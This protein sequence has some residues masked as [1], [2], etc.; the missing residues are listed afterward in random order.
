MTPYDRIYNILVEQYASARQHGDTEYRR[1]TITLKNDPR[2]QN[3]SIAASD[4]ERRRR[5]RLEKH[6]KLSDAPAK[7]IPGSAQSLKVRLARKAPLRQATRG[8]YR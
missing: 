4:A 1:N 5:A 3:P 6:A 8:G 2:R 7:D